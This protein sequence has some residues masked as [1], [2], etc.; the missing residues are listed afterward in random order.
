VWFYVMALHV[1]PWLVEAARMISP[2][3]RWGPP[4]TAEN[5]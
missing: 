2:A 5:G 1:A 4:S 3:R